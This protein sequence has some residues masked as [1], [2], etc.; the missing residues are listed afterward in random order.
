MSVFL[1][2][3]KHHALTTYDKVEVQ[4]NAFLLS[5]L[6][7]EW[8]LSFT[9]RPLYDRQ[10]HWN[11]RDRRLCRAHRWSWRREKAKVLLPNGSEILDGEA[12][13]PVTILPL[14]FG[15]QILNFLSIITL[16]FLQ[17]WIWKLSSSEMWRHAVW[18]RYISKEHPVRFSTLKIETVQSSKNLVIIYQTTL[19]HI[20]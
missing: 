16:R 14:L 20:P 3:F 7:G 19:R 10:W 15:P 13:S 17:R 4:L 1:C 11:A 2:L 18:N 6:H 5:A 8:S 12:H 9:Q